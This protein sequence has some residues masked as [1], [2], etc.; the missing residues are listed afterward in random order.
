MINIIK[1]S[2]CV[3]LIISMLLLIAACSGNETG[4]EPDTD[5]TT[6][7]AED[8]TGL[9]YE[10][11]ELPSDLNFGGEKITFLT[12]KA[13]N[14]SD[15]DIFRNE[16]FAEELSNDPI[17]DSIYNRER[18]VEDRIGVEIEH[19]DVDLD[20][21][22]K[23]VIVQQTSDEDIY[24]VYA[25]STVWFAPNVFNNYLQNLYDVDYLD[26]S[27]PWWSDLFAEQAEIMGD[28]YLATGSISLS[29]I[30]FLFVTFY[31][32]T[33]AENFQARY[34]DLEDLYS[35]VENGDWTFD[36]FYEICSNIYEDSNGNSESDEEDLFGCVF[37]NGIDID[38]M[39]SSFDIIIFSRD[40][41]GWFV[42]DVNTDKLYSALDMINK[43][44]HETTGCYVPAN[45]EDYGLN[46]LSDKF[47][48]STA[49]FM[50]NKLHAAESA[51]LR[52]MQD[53]Y[54]IV[55]FPKYDRTQK[56]YYTYAH[57][58][59]LSYSIPV[60]NQNPDTAG[61]VLEAM[62]SYSYR[63]TRPIYLDM[64]LK[65]RYMND[66]QSRKMVDR[67]VAGFKLDSSWIYNQSTGA[68]GAAFREVIRDHSTSYSVTYAKQSKEVTTG[69]KLLKKM[70][71]P[72]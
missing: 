47:A 12:I 15:N 29:L 55:P 28:L 30:R 2:V 64:V 1:K 4:P 7:G 69:L 9:Q 59:Y 72:S 67:I 36:R 53:E 71:Q 38:T 42:L 51:V 18:F 25:A 23:T 56:D 14:E 57:D 6:S 45:R 70:F 27:K 61:A 24:Q 63:E 50:V 8:T 20:D 31:N 33:I 41:E 60:T 43:L 48:S 39:W 11:D 58:Q 19:Y 22:N 17:N 46:E 16:V 32:K 52:N 68:F 62:A 10:A 37:L 13:K 49:L 3:L 65:G 34:P 35:V 5:G 26:F 21:Y 44:V 66:P 54:G 40:D